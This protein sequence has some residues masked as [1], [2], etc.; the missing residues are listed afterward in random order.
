MHMA[1]GRRH[2]AEAER[3]AVHRQALAE[4]QRPRR[5]PVPKIMTRAE[6]LARVKYARPEATMTPTSSLDGLRQRSYL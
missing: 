3:A 1:R 6:Q 2:L 4:R 5:E